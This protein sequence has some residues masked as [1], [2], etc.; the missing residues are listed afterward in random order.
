MKK[1][2]SVFI[3]V[4]LLL[5]FAGCSPDLD[6]PAN[7]T[8]PSAPQEKQHTYLDFASAE[9]ELLI[10]YIGEVIPF[11][12]NNE[13]TFSRLESEAEKETFRFRAV[14]NTAEEFSAYRNTFL[15][16]TLSK[17]Y[18]DDTGKTWFEYTKGDLTVKLAYYAQVR[19]NVIDVYI[20]LAKPADPGTDT[21]GDDPNAGG[22]GGAAINHTYSD[23]S[24]S[25]KALFNQYI[26]ALIPFLPND[27]YYIEGYYEETDYENGLC[28]I[29]IGNTEAE[30]N[31][32]RN[33]FSS[34]IFTDSYV[35]NEYGDTWYC[36]RKGDVEVELTY[37]EYEG[38]SYVEVYIISSLSQTPDDGG[39]GSGN[40]NTPADIIVNDGKGLP[41]DSDGVF[42]VDFTTATNVKDVTD[43]GYYL[44]GCPPVGSPDVL[45]IPINFKDG[46]ALT[47]ANIDLIELA[48]GE[49][50]EY[51]HS[52]YNYYYLSSYGK[53]TLDVNVLD[54]WYEPAQNSTYYANLT[55]GEGNPNGDQ[56][57]MDEILKKLSETMDLSLFD[58]DGNT[59]ID[60]IVLINNLEVGEDDFHWAYRYWNTYTDDDGYYYEYDGVSANDY[61]WASYYF[62]HEYTDDY[63]T[64]YS[65]TSVMNT[66]TYIHEFG[67]VLGADDYYDTSNAGNH[68]M[69]GLDVMDGMF[70]DHNAYTKFNLGWVTTSRLV[71]T[72]S[73]VTLNLEDFSKNGDT[74]L[75]A[76]NWDPS[77]GAYQEYYI[78]VY[79]TNNGLNSGDHSYFSRDGIVVYHINA[80]LFKEEYG[81]ETYYDV[82]NNNTD[83]SDTEYG[84]EDNLIEFVKSA[85]GNYTYIPGDT[86][87]T[88]TDDSGNTLDYTFTVDAL[89]AD[90]ATITFTKR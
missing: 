68:P 9:K 78:V 54:F 24:S 75:I 90:T 49:N 12:P 13:Y 71:V 17:T 72:D 15:G 70:G 26:G 46:T 73:S 60:A 3:S 84:T 35:D 33:A 37:Y 27:E 89:T 41:S 76:N 45:V 43:Q 1:L 74:I 81:G 59:V 32:Y 61:I 23:W 80:S 79:Y 25:D 40:N 10:Q 18:T 69:N 85:A 2:L 5:S 57:L 58:S 53:L 52:V 20:Q 55:D 63:G 28:F 38:E 6:H 44:D 7:P 64:D 19:A 4:I 62:L 11:V 42:D 34:Y 86:L 29:T 87:P 56:V 16:Y 47:A 31:A 48:F 67:H 77:L 8:I 36:Y 14:G 66:Y 83:P 51:E 65:D 88:T 30:Y 82:Y 22:N 39:P 50:G 21:P